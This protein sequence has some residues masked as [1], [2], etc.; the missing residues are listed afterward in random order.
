MYLKHITIENFKGHTCC[1]LNLKPAFTLLIG[2]N[3]MGKTSILEAAAVALGGFLAGV[4]DISTNHFKKDDIRITQIPMGEGSFHRQYETPVRVSAVAQIEEEEY[5]WTRCKTS[6]K[7]TR[8]TV[9]P[10][11]IKEIAKRLSRDP[12]G[13]LPVLSYQSAARLWMDRGEKMEN[14]FHT[15]FNRTAGY[16][17]CLKG[18]ADTKALLNWCA[19]M[20]QVAWQKG[21]KIGEYESVKNTLSRFMCAMNEGEE[22]QIQFDKQNSELSYVAGDMALPIG[23]LSAGY[24]SMIWMVLDIAFRMA[25]LNPNLMEKASDSPGIVLIDE[26]DM[27]LHPNWQWKIIGALQ[28]V[29]PNVQFIAATHSPILIASYKKGQLIQVERDEILYLDSGYGLEI[30]DVLRSAQGSQDMAASL[31]EQLDML[32]NLIDQGEFQEAKET[33]SVLEK[34]L[35]ADHPEVNKVKT[36]LTFETAVAKEGI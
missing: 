4:P 6:E 36:A 13:V 32:Y 9:D 1:T 16:V 19:K 18:T 15:A 10:D 2:D 22:V 25:V 11:A 33:V 27:H 23:N 30:N 5:K 14:I 7:A 34:E 26:L 35:G 29:F 24:Q 21:K 17:N 28:K 20:E 3:G 8:S 31:K 12:E